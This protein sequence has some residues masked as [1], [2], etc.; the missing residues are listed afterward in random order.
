[1]GHVQ[2]QSPGRLAR[3]LERSDHLLQAQQRRRA[4]RRVQTET[5][6]AGV[7]AGDNRLLFV[8]ASEQEERGSEQLR[9]C[10]RQ[11]EPKVPCQR[12]AE[13]RTQER[14]QLLECQPVQTCLYLRQR[15]HCSS[16]SPRRPCVFASKG[17]KRTAKCKAE[18]L[19][20]T[21]RNGQ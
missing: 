8:C 3:Q 12:P 17:Q 4:H 9:P 10:G 21:N 5:E 20:I 7:F 1:M 19:V 14:L 15:L 11:H 6:L 16:Q 18:L 13:Q 2:R